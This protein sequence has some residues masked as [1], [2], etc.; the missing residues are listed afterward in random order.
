M[1]RLFALLLLALGVIPLV[2][3]QPAKPDPTQL[4]SLVDGK[5]IVKTNPFSD[6]F[7][8]LN[9]KVERI[10]ARGLSAQLSAYYAPK[11]SESVRQNGAFHT[12]S[13]VLYMMPLAA[14]QAKFL[15]LRPQLRWYLN[16]GKGHGFYVEGYYQFQRSS[17]RNQQITEYY[18]SKEGK[19]QY[20]SLTYDGRSTLH[21]YGIGIGAQWLLGRRKNIVLDWYILGVGRGIVRGSF[22]GTSMLEG[23]PWPAGDHTEEEA[24]LRRR[25][26]SVDDGAKYSFDD[27]AHQVKVTNIKH[28]AYLLDMGLSIGFRF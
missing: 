13:S 20:Y 10:L 9:L 12:Y 1:K 3:Q 28:T 7:G 19:S 14:D 15:T 4:Y 18:P 21:G 27:A 11:G 25:L 17:F 16:E 24:L 8:N 6:L 23:S 22:D 2:A 5:T 26:Y